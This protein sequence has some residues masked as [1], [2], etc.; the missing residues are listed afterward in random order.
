MLGVMI[1][2]WNDA[3]TLFPWMINVAK[4]NKNGE[5]FHVGGY[6][7]CNKC[8][9]VLSAPRQGALLS[10]PCRRHC[11]SGSKGRRKRMRKGL[12]PFK[13][14]KNW[15]DGR[16]SKL[17]LRVSTL[18][19]VRNESGENAQNLTT[20]DSSSDSASENDPIS[21]DEI[22]SPEVQAQVALACDKAWQ[23]F[24]DSF[25]FD[26]APLDEL[27]TA[28]SRRVVCKGLLNWTDSAAMAEMANHP[29]FDEFERGLVYWAAG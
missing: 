23:S 16:S 24:S 7:F 18:P 20:D 8:G 6:L 15:P 10:E 26:A 27:V 14:Y 12:I 25:L 3:G 22:I 19:F 1:M 11:P 2:K 9:A 5:L 4:V 29:E 17:R 13:C 28:T 21:N